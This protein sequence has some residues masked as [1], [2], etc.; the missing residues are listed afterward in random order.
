MF[1]RKSGERLKWLSDQKTSFIKSLL[2]QLKDQRVLTF[3]NS[4][5]QTEILGKYCI[6]SSNSK[7]SSTH[8]EKFNEGEVNHI[9]ACAMLDEGINLRNCRVGIYGMLNSSERIIKQRLGRL[10]RH[11]NPVIIIPYYEG[12]RDEELVNKMLEDYNQDLVS[13]ITNL[14]DLTL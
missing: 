4:I 11:P 3:C 7:L 10:L 6:N 12:T 8:L 2:D 1:L 5:L 14:K 13:K 9:T